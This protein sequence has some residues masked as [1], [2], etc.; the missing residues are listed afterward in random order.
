MLQAVDEHESSVSL[1][2]SFL[3]VGVLGK[4]FAEVLLL[5]SFEVNCEGEDDEKEDLRTKRSKK[6]TQ[7]PIISSFR[8]REYWVLG[9]IFL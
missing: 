6:A 8:F 4:S 9:L 2:T 5:S 1:F 7:T 3:E